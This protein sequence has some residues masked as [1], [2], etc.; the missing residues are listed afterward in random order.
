MCVT[1]FELL[2]LCSL[3][4][5]LFRIKMNIKMSQK[6]RIEC[7]TSAANTLFVRIDLVRAINLSD[8]I[9]QVYI[10]SLV[11]NLLNI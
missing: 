2:I 4:L 11:M 8:R 7:P 1:S 9:K 10:G 5:A 6:C 3:F